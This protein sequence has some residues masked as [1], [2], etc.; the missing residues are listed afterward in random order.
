MNS[1]SE[2]RLSVEQGAAAEPFDVLGRF[3]HW[4]RTAPH[5]PA[6]E[7]GQLRWTYAELDA[8]ADRAAQ[9]LRGRVRPGD[10][11]GVCLDRSVALVALA[12]ALARLDAVYLPLGPRP[13]ERRLAAVAERLDVACL[14]GDPALLPVSHEGGE[15]LALP[16][17]AEGANAAAEVV[18]AFGPARDGR[19]RAPEGAFYAVLTSGSTGVPKAV[20]V[21]GAS[22]GALLSWYAGHTGSGPGDRHSL[23][24]GVAFDPHLMELW[25]ALTT[26]AALAVP[27]EEVRWDPQAL[28][29]WWRR[30]GVSCAILPTPLAELVFER[31]WPGLP[32]LRHLVVGGD[33]LRRWPAP[34]VTARVHN[35]YGPAEATVSTTVHTLDPVLQDTAVAPPIGL[36]VDG[37]V[38]CVTDDAGRVVPRGEPGELR[39]GGGCLALGYLD[40]ELTAQRFVPAPPGV[41]GARRVYRTGD[42]VR[43]RADGVLEFLGRID[44]QVKVSGVRVEPAEV[45]AA[46][47]RDSRVRRAAVAARPGPSGDVQ[48]LAFVQPAPGQ[49]GVPAA[50]LLDAVRD[51]LPEQA[52]PA[53]L[54]HVDAFPLDANGKVDRG[55]LLAA[56]ERR[57]AAE[58]AEA[59][60]A[61]GASA[62]VAVESTEELV[63][64]LC[65]ELLGG[66]ALGPLDNF[67]TAGGTSLV[68][69]RLL[70]ALEASCGVRL[71]APE[72]L[73]QPDLRSLA[74][75]VDA[76]R[77]TAP[78]G[79]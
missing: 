58:A 5:A 28:T 17:P 45:E 55:A 60:A 20:A 68:A 70:A 77:A 21:G 48:L 78:A 69:A 15:R 33:R 53:R 37:A 47:E 12:V 25:A 44:D 64:R 24:I 59:A 61:S 40:E 13:G 6:V 29:D 63:V 73:R 66:S 62:A 26:G 16:L 19:D 23:L 76:R 41:S 51:W 1:I 35:V 27:P 7:D 22:L 74:A 46:L 49:E 18:A 3:D 10:L 54:D 11:V 67:R 39:I 32:G 56:E 71:R 8:L 34:E 50:E 36:P 52:V 9:A 30:A 14:V 75:L 4:V 2:Q 65:G 72:V 57:S 42:R 31:P 79:A 43:M 38:L